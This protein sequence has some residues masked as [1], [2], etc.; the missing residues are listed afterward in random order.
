MRKR[1]KYQNKRFIQLVMEKKKISTE[2]SKKHKTHT[3]IH[4]SVRETGLKFKNFN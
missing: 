4:E 1:D 3:E 2:K